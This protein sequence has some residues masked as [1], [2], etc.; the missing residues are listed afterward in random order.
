MIRGVAVG[1]GATVAGAASRVV[2]E[3]RLQAGIVPGAVA[4]LEITGSGTAE[5][6][7]PERRAV[8]AESG[9]GAVGGAG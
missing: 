8:A 6:D 5:G 9:A 7:E 3:A 2:R 1:S 4:A